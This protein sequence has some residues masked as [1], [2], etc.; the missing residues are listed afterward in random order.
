MPGGSLGLEEGR[1][2]KMHL[3]EGKSGS[4]SSLGLLE[5]ILNNLD[6]VRNL[7]L[8]RSLLEG[9]LECSLEDLQGSLDLVGNNFVDSLGLED[10]PCMDQT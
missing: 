3:M 6:Q 4:R 9:S 5:G 8:L 2:G 10:N 1:L 7:E